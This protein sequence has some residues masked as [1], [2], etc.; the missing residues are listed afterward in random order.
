MRI[1]IIGTGRIAKRF[2]P[3]CEAVPGTEIT[4][5]Y[6]P[7]EGSAEKFVDYIRQNQGDFNPTAASD[8]EILWERTD[9]VYVASPHETHYSYIIEA[10]EHGKHVLCE[11]PLTLK[12]AQ[13]EE[14]C[15]QAEKAGIV[16][17][18][19]LKTV[20]CPGYRKVLELARDGTIGDIKYIDACFTK[21]EDPSK[22]ELQDV[23]YG[24]SFTELGSYVLLPAMDIFGT[25]Y[26]NIAFDP[27]INDK[28]VDTFTRTTVE[29]EDAMATLTCGLGVKSEGRLLIS[30]T[31]GYIKADAP[32]W[33]T[34]HIEVHFEDES[35]TI[36]HDEPFEGDGLRYE[37]GRFKELTT[38]PAEE[39][40]EKQTHERDRSTSMASIMERFL[41]KRGQSA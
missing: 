19:G 18:E 8:I 11:K 22:R 32:W 20:Y 24:G 5:V 38:F 34:R 1:G 25:E 30:G 15:W 4:A 21:L 14:A 2:V 26:N 37:L 41:A 33:K 9:A 29:Y 3:A 7:H 27:I 12:K 40:K 13:A 39:L 28:G 10:I 36:A 17:M 35:K 16:L 6:N 31:K 23:R